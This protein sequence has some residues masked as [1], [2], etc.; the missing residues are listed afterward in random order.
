MPVTTFNESIKFDEMPIVEQREGE[1]DLATLDTP[2]RVEEDLDRLEKLWE[3]LPEDDRV[4]EEPAYQIPQ[5]VVLS[6]VIPVY[7]E[8]ATILE[9]VARVKSL[10]VTTEI[11]VVDDCSTD[12]TRGWLQ[13]IKG[14]PGLKVLLKMR[15][16]GK[17]A[18]LRTGFE[19]A[20]GDI[21]VVQDA[22]L[23]YDPC[24]ILKVIQ[25]IVEGRADV[26]YGS[27]FSGDE[28]QDRSFFHRSI[29]RSLTTFSNLFTGLRLTDMETCYKAFRRNVVRE[30]SLR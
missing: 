25:P 16:E 24:D 9:V 22:D 7:N 23:E 5:Q 20:T 6:V 1:I 14:A 18:A 17:G 2:R 10:P 4:A 13:T 28:Q 26:A 21:L 12:G 27:R 19:A 30:I 3:F 29:N 15:N 11:I 8:K